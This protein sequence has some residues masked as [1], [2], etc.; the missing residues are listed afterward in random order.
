MQQRILD[1]TRDYLA[2]FFDCPVRVK[3]QIAL[4][5]TPARARRNHPSWGDEQMLSGYVL[6]EVLEQERPA[7]DLGYLALIAPDLSP[8]RGRNFVFGEANLREPVGVWSIYRNGDPERDFQLC[9]RRTL[10]TASHETGHILGMW[11]CTDY[12]WLMNGSN[13]QDEKDRRPMH[14]CPVC[15]GASSA[16]TC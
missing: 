8:W 15:E 1:L 10:S 5:S 11:H 12:Y 6:H 13:Q 14:Q 3:R 16:G 9:L 4:H 7:D 2:L